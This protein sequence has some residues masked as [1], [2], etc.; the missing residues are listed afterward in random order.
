M[1]SAL[2]EIVTVYC[3]TSIAVFTSI[4]AQK[5]IFSRELKKK[6]YIL[7]RMCFQQLVFCDFVAVMQ[8]PVGLQKLAD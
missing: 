3:V 8:K 7:Q 2:I 5:S 6:I 4:T 1:L